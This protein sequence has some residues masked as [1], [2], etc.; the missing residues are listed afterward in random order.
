M[1]TLG[2][3][4]L[5]MIWMKEWVEVSKSARWG[6]KMMHNLLAV[7]SRLCYLFSTSRGWG[8]DIVPNQHLGWTYLQRKVHDGAE[9]SLETSRKIV[10]SHSDRSLLDAFQELHAPQLSRMKCHS[11]CE[12]KWTRVW[13][14]HLLKYVNRGSANPGLLRSW[15]KKNVL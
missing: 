1:T 15:W 8:V 3:Q 10:F 11:Y 7:F 2:F 5:G 9:G 14:P 4:C 13:A 12:G 6:K